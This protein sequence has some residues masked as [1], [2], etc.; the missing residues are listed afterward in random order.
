MVVIYCADVILS[1]NVFY[2][3]ALKF[4]LLW[5]QFYFMITIRKRMV[6]AMYWKLQNDLG[7]TCSMW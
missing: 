1:F 3:T 7:L 4:Q 5:D 2:A 6:F